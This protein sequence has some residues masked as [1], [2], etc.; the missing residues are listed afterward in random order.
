MGGCL[1]WLAHL[2]GVVGVRRL[3]QLVPAVL[4][5]W[6]SAGTL[7]PCLLGTSVA[8]AAGT[9]APVSSEDGTALGR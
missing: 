3:L 9:S 8:R 5:L 7:Y 2:V 6:Y 1:S 4:C